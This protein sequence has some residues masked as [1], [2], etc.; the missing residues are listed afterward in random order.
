MRVDRPRRDV[1]PREGPAQHA[2]HLA[3]E[4][5]CPDAPASAA[6]TGQHR[7][8]V[9]ARLHDPESRRRVVRAQ[10]QD[11]VVELARHLQ[12]PPARAGGDDVVEV[13]GAGLL[14][15]RDTVI[16]AIRCRAVDRDVDVLVVIAALVDRSA[17]AASARCPC[18]S[19]RPVA[20]RRAARSAR[21][22]TYR[23]EA[24]RLDDGVDEPQSFARVAFHAIG[25]SCRRHPPDRA[26]RAVCR[27]ARV[28]P[29]VPGSTPSSG[30]SGRLTADDRSSTR[31]ISSQ[32]SASSYPPPGRRAVARRKELQSGVLARVFD[33]VARL[34]RELAEVHFPGVA[35]V[36]QH[37]DVG[38]GTEHA[39]F[40]RSR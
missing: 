32:A 34:V 10:H 1:E 37:V 29:P 18:A 25:R 39:V 4:P 36:A 5:V 40:R 21:S 14:P 7:S 16:V 38:A 15:V 12:R 22:S 33:A 20:L 8:R 24:S 27:S 28:K 31:T 23:V 17:P 11:R 2:K 13:V 6:S 3:N 9:A 30:T 19:G 35:R 26:A